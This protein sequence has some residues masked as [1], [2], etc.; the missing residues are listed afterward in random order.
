M[1][2]PTSTIFKFLDHQKFKRFL[3]SAQA[4]GVHFL[5]IED[6]Y[7]YSLN[8]RFL[9][10]FTYRTKTPKNP[11]DLRHRFHDFMESQGLRWVTSTRVDPCDCSVYI[12]GVSVAS[13][14][15]YKEHKFS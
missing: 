15:F 4:Y 1:Q 5:G 8:S 6:N 3:L 10:R 12:F 2:L 7:N 14:S 11:H 13:D 9:L